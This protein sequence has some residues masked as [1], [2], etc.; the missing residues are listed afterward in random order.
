MINLTA[1][2]HYVHPKTYKSQVT[3]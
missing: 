3:Y 1:L 2:D